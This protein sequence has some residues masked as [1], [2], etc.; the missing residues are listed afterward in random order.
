MLARNGQSCGLRVGDTI[1]AI[2]GTSASTPLFAGLVG[3][4]NEARLA[5]G[6]KAMGF[7]NP[8]IYQHASAFTD[9]TLGT[10][11]AG[12]G[13]VPTPT[14]LIRCVGSPRLSKNSFGR[15]RVVSTNEPFAGGTRVVYGCGADI[16]HRLPSS[17]NR[18]A[19]TLDSPQ[20]S[21]NLKT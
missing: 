14:P 1:V 21:S 2:G 11:A 17:L 13:P 20:L 6:G 9:V 19:L 10:N 12:R 8:W 15:S 16:R 4:L 7:L 3:L 18:C 5:K